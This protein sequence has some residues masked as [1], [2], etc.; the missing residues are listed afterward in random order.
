MTDPASVPTTPDEAF[1]RVRRSV[2]ACVTATIATNRHPAYRPDGAFPPALTVPLLGELRAAVSLHFAI[3]D[4]VFFGDPP[5]DIAPWFT[6]DPAMRGTGY[7]ETRAA[8]CLFGS[9]L[10]VLSRA[11]RAGGPNITQ[12]TNALSTMTRFHE[13]FGL[14]PGAV[15]YLP[16]IAGAETGFCVAMETAQWQA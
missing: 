12:V 1:D 13:P 9:L 16:E 8:V 4:A 15:L 2:A 11:I 3:T 14:L 6:V 7:V 5:D 10:T